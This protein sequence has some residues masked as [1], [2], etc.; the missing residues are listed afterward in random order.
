MESTFL[1]LQTLDNWFMSYTNFQ[2]LASFK[3]VYSTSCTDLKDVN[4]CTTNFVCVS[5][6]HKNGD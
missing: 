2:V 6:S 3:Q 1:T 5:P 4:K